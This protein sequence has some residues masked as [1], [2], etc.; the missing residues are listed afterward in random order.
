VCHP[1]G[2]TVPS[3]SDCRSNGPR[4]GLGSLYMTQGHTGAPYPLTY[5]GAIIAPPRLSGV[6]WC[7]FG[8]FRLH[9]PA[10]RVAKDSTGFPESAATVPPL[11]VLPTISVTRWPCLPRRSMVKPAFSSA[12]S[13]RVAAYR[14]KLRRVTSETTPRHVW[15]YTGPYSFLSSSFSIIDMTLTA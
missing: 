10:G 7:V 11:K 9:P 3:P 1:Q 4:H 2:E 14:L 6:H 5:L 8:M 12:R 15:S 13:V